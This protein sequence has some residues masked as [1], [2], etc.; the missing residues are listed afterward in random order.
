MHFEHQDVGQSAVV[1]TS[2]TSCRLLS[3]HM[4]VTLL[5]RISD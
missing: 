2:R 3:F 5:E 4:N 1:F